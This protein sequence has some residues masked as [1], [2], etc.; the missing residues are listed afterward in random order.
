MSGAVKEGLGSQESVKQKLF[1]STASYTLKGVRCRHKGGLAKKVFTKFS[2]KVVKKIKK[3][4]EPL[5]LSCIESR[6]EN[7][8]NFYGRFQ[9][10]PFVLGQGLTI[11]NSLRRSLLSE[12]SG[13]S[14]YCR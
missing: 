5:L 9:L 6:V 3:K 7:S 1:A 10:G 13:F 12:I 2:I 4:M 11:A 14:Y 8:R